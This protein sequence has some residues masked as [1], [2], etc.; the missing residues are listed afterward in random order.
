[1]DDGGKRREAETDAT[2]VGDQPRPEK[3]A[4]FSGPRAVPPEAT[5]IAGSAGSETATQS[6]LPDSGSV[7][8]GSVDCGSEDYGSGQPTADFTDWVGPGSGR[9]EPDQTLRAPHDLMS[10]GLEV[11]LD[12]TVHV[13]E[14]VAEDGV[15]A[16]REAGFSVDS[17]LGEGGMGTVFAGRQDS[18]DRP[19][20]I[21]V[22]KGDAANVATS[23]QL[24]VSEAI[25]TG[26]L[27][28]PNIVP[29]YD[30]GG[31]DRQAPFYAMK[32]IE[33]VEWSDRFSSNSV[34]ENL[35]I[36]LRVCD[37]V[38]FAHQRGIIHR[39]L[40]PA[41]IMLGPFG[42]VLVMDWGLAIPA[43]DHPKRDRF[44]FSPL[45]GTPY[46]MAP[47]MV[48]DVGKIDRRS[49][50]YLL[51]GILFAIVTGKAPHAIDDPPAE[52]RE[53]LTGTF[54]AV[55]RNLIAPTERS[56]KLLDIAL[57]ALSTDP[58][59]RHQTVGEFQQAIRDYR[60]HQESIALA[61][62]SHERLADARASED[63]VLFSRARF[64]FETALEQWPENEH[65]RDG[66]SAACL[67]YAET[68][69]RRGDYD[70][71][72]SLLTEDDSDHARL[73]A[74]IVSAIAER[75]SRQRQVTLFKRLSIAA[76]ALVAVIA[77]GAA[78]WIKSEHSKAETARIAES[79]QREI[80]TAERENAVAAKLKAEQSE[81]EAVRARLASEA[82]ERSAVEARLAA[83]ESERVAK[84]ERDEAERQAYY[85][86]MMLIKESAA[87]FNVLHMQELLARHQAQDHLRN[88]EWRYWNRQL[89][90]SVYASKPG[91]STTSFA[92]SPDGR[93]LAATQQ[94]HVRLYDVRSPEN[95]RLLRGATQQLLDV[96]FSPDGQTVAAVGHDVKL[97]LWDFSS[98]QISK[99]LEG[100]NGWMTGVAFSPDGSRIVTTSFDRTAVVWDAHTGEALFTYDKS[101][102]GLRT[103]AFHPDG[104]RIAV[105]GNRGRV[106][107]WD[108]ESGDQQLTFWS[109]QSIIHRLSFSANGEWMATA[110]EDGR[111]ILWS[112][113]SGEK[114]VEMVEHTSG[115]RDVSFSPNNDFLVS[116]GHDRV[117]RVWSVPSGERLHAF[118]GHSGVVHAA[119]VS[120][121]GS[122]IAAG[123][124]AL[125]LWQPYGGAATDEIALARLWQPVMAVEPDRSTLVVGGGNG[126]L[127]AID[128]ASRQVTDQQ[129]VLDGS[130]R[131]VVISPDGMR[132][133]ASSGRRIDLRS[134]RPDGVIKLWP[135]AR[136]AAQGN[137]IR[138]GEEDSRE[139][140]GIPQ[141][142]DGLSFTGDGK[143]LVSAN[144][145]STVSI[146]DAA[147]GSKLH[148]LLG[149]TQAVLDVS[150]D[151]FGK[152]IA[153]VGCDY[154]LR[155]WDQETRKNLIDRFEHPTS[156]MTVCEF[157]PDGR[158][159]V[160]GHWYG[161][162]MLWDVESGERVTVQA[163]HTGIVSG[164]SFT[165]DGKRLASSSRDG[166]VKVWDAANL[167]ET[168][169]FY[170]PSPV[171]D[172]EFRTDGRQLVA[173]L[174]NRIK[175]W[176][177]SPNDEQQRIQTRARGYLTVHT[178]RAESLDALKQY[179]TDDETITDDVRKAVLAMADLTWMTRDRE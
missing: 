40:K 75:R 155:V 44:P 88:F 9:T 117:V 61:R 143:H 71:A 90:E 48:L 14:Q 41:N 101:I 5:F 119:A 145:D 164:I 170:E 105:S 97:H 136:D 64:G 175:L 52:V 163:G 118:L 142:V 103:L 102:D 160:T 33:G 179:V 172:V 92:F 133:A 55:S 43:P 127:A 79:K 8:C 106:D 73:F 18:M 42:E 87:D 27:D 10:L 62:K 158:H 154:H 104:K 153:S 150:C 178:R 99:S 20:A 29:I 138:F 84:R 6:D 34:E 156:W 30:V 177:A 162:L 148:D 63:Y 3:G 80:A 137:A 123:D 93:T 149:N 47:E 68:A 86:D 141:G 65:A 128:L 76:V 165:A 116:A 12:P 98:G 37:A 51:G 45:G 31:Q 91:Q 16:A 70:L 95:S 135:R 168:L 32:Q 67:A 25:I 39:D 46:Y 173:A 115:V 125:R 144:H 59:E 1:M 166:S 129:H 78:I 13:H 161:H 126:D 109:E 112:A 94:Q 77:T 113:E 82:S 38:A 60:A 36:L 2:F 151:P 134:D 176:D 54:E 22:L 114:I 23:Q 26:S 96:A 139:I 53:K 174:D 130:V 85:S 28:H 81:R 152:F 120:P 72:K 24:F 66:L 167:R 19:V 100:H 4:H 21:K 69:F 132:L 58:A 108:V 131:D 56:G 35:E 157:H 7:D 121:D 11:E 15:A 124:T 111:V 169:A 107:V 17:V 146:F 83:E 140:R 147:T 171:W 159:L 50:V 110:G 89:D 57:E 49:D 74:S 122:L